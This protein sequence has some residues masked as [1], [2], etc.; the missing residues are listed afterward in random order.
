VVLVVAPTP[1]AVK[2]L[3]LAGLL[4]QLVMSHPRLPWR[5]SGQLQQVRIDHAHRVRLLYADGRVTET[6]LR[7]DSVITPAWLLLRFEGAGRWSHTSLLLGPDSLSGDELRRLRVLLRFGG[8][9]PER[10]Q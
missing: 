6:W 5:S 3:L 10:T 9:A 2:M 8:S 4:L 7:V 1:V